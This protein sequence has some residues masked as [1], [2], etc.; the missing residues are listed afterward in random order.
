M[1]PLPDSVMS[2]FGQNRTSVYDQE[3]RKCYLKKDHQNDLTVL[4]AG[5]RI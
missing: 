2:T 1:Y 4:Q 3:F 5:L